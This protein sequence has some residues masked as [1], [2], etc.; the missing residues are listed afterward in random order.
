MVEQIIH[1]CPRCGAELSITGYLEVCEY[2]G[3]HDEVDS[4]IGVTDKRAISFIGILKQN[5]RY[6]M[7]SPLLSVD[8]D[9]PSNITVKSIMRYSPFDSNYNPFTELSIKL[10]YYSLKDEE[11]LSM[12][13]TKA[14]LPFSPYFH[15]CVDGIIIPLQLIDQIK[16]SAFYRM[17]V[18]D[19]C[20]ICS[21]RE[22][23]VKTNCHEQ[24]LD[25]SDFPIFAK[26]FYNQAFDR[27]RFIFSLNKRLV[28][29][30][31]DSRL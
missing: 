12:I 18:E 4:G 22:L 8:Y 24:E 11:Y 28:C 5:L 15:F 1:V 25:Y 6:A 13:A 26:R 20:L 19:F 2:C 14:N 16:G 21:A 7:Q 29:E 31:D 17:T 10:I 23:F 30:R 27:R 9:G 3:Y